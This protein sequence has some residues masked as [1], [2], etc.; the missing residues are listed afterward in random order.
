MR[1][2]TWALGCLLLS[3]QNQ[4]SAD[5]LPHS[6]SHPPSPLLSRIAALGSLLGLMER[7]IKLLKLASADALPDD[8]DLLSGSFSLLF[9]SSLSFLS[10]LSFLSVLSSL[11]FLA[12]PSSLFPSSWHRN[13]TLSCAPSRG[14]I[15]RVRGC[16]WKSSS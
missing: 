14:M 13:L 3:N 2:R 12:S 5:A 16:T 6:L 4:G 15:D 10:F 1:P 8:T 7:L 11:S 9:L